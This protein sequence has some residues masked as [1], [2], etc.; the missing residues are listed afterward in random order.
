MDS[1]SAAQLLAQQATELARTIAISIWCGNV[2]IAIFLLGHIHSCRL[3]GATAELIFN[4]G[5]QQQPE[6]AGWS[7]HIPGMEISRI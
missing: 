5:E 4:V 2:P 6:S 7:M 3:L 1:A